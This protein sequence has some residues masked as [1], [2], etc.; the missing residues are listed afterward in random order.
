MRGVDDEHLQLGHI[1]RRGDEKP[2]GILALELIADRR[3]IDEGVDLMRLKRRDLGREMAIGLAPSSPQ[4]LT[5]LS[6]STSH[7]VSDPCVETPIVLPLR[8]SMVF[9]VESA[10]TM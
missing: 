5:R 6:S 10:P 9:A 1:L 8:S 2:A 3:R 4:P 7:L